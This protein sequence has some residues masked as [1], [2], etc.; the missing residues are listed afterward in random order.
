MLRININSKEDKYIRDIK[1][2]LKED[3]EIMCIFT[4]KT[5]N[6]L[7]SISNIYSKIKKSIPTTRVDAIDHDIER[8]RYFLIINSK[9]EMYPATNAK[10]ADKSKEAPTEDLTSTKAASVKKQKNIHTIVEKNPSL[11]NLMEEYLHKSETTG[12]YEL[13]KDVNIVHLRNIARKEM[14]KWNTKI[15][16]N[17]YVAKSKYIQ[18][19]M[20]RGDG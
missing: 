13:L 1:K 11:V 5:E 9:S 2:A 8:N 14:V 18:E 4:L 15:P 3:K 10:S 7:K 19:L 20:R 12:Q 16:F 6:S 17:E